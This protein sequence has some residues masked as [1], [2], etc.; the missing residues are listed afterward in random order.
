MIKVNSIRKYQPIWQ[1]LKDKSICEV[2]AHTNLHRRII[3]A[4]I[5]E[6]YNDLK[7]KLFLADK[8]KR[9]ILEHT[10]K[11]NVITFTLVISI[12]VGDL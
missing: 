7:F 1:V 11:H 8:G 9:A 6:K 3:K 10:K 2:A 4:V 12:G 5:K